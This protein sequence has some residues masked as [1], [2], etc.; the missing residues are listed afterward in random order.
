[1]LHPMFM[2]GSGGIFIGS[3]GLFD[4]PSLC[5]CKKGDKVSGYL[6]HKA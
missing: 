2:H 1:M 3:F 6:Y 4:R 5:A